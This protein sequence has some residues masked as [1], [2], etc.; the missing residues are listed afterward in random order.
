[1]WSRIAE[2]MA[3]PWRAAEAMHWQIGEQE[4]ARRAGVT[5]FSLT[6]NLNQQIPS[7]STGSV[8]PHPPRSLAHMRSSSATS[9]MRRDSQGGPGGYAVSVQPPSSN[10]LPPQLPSLAELTAGLP[11]YSCNSSLGH[12][13]PPMLTPPHHMYSH[14][15]SSGYPFHRSRYDTTPATHATLPS[16]SAAHSHA[17][18]P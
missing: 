14:S 2:E 11:A 15:A 17:S 16:A 8:L 3:I 6:T 18:R 12:P 13:S 9:R 4:M 1:M 7:Q 10:G 5:P